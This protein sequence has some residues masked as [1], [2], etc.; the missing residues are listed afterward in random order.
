MNI[1]LAS[2][3]DASI[4]LALG[5]GLAAVLRR[6]SAAL[7]H[8]VLATAIGCAMLMPALELLMPQL[9]LVRW[10]E[11]AAATTSGLTLSSDATV[12]GAAVT[13]AESSSSS[14]AFK[15][16]ML[17]AAL[18]AAGVLV[19]LSGLVVGLWRLRRLRASCTPVLSGWRSVTD[20]LARECGVT[21]TIQVLQSTDPALLVTYG[22]FKPGIILPAGA[23]DWTEDRQ[24]VVLR[25]ELAHIRRHDAAIHV[26]GELLR[27]MQP[28]NPLVW[29]VCRRLRQESEYACDDAVL[30]AGVEP[31]VYASHLLDVAKR[32]SG[33]QTLWAAAPAIAHPSTLERRIVAML[34]HQMNRQPLTRG[35]WRLAAVFAL[36]VS[37]PLAAVGV[38]P[39]P[40]VG[41]P[42]PQSTVVTD[43][44]VATLPT[45][46][47][48]GDAPGKVVPPSRVESPAK[49]VRRAQ[50]SLSGQVQDQT[51]GRIPGAT[52]TLVNQQTQESRVAVTNAPGAFQFVN[53]PPAPYVLVTELIGFRKRQVTID[54]SAGTPA[55]LIVTLEVG[56][57]S[58]AITVQCQTPSPSILQRLFPTLLAQE[59]SVPIR[60]GGH[61]K[62]PRKAKDARPVC[63]AAGV[64][65]DV[66]VL[67]E[68][69]IGVDG[70]VTNLKSLSS[71]APADLV[72]SA[73]DA[74]LKWEFTPTLLNGVPVEVI[75]TV[76]VRYTRG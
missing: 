20:E 21:S 17:V 47:N 30:C 9:P 75:M 23:D 45:A 26:A 71:D 22:M 43:S 65:A 54:L 41:V 66:V 42:P 12:V 28:F 72:E 31:T 29:V 73:K 32:L 58:E 34:H 25:H 1:L 16:P 39:Q 13:T 61:I 68:G 37:L 64:T 69:H 76:T 55:N 2:I 7:R 49:A 18:W 51:G 3:I 70:F 36:G 46:T 74:V 60:I 67:L 11:S 56:A 24:R 4:V 15:W 10:F 48:P 27:V 63:P 57:L 8:A 53:L 33:H 44:P 35:A 19:T 62:P 38:A 52:V 59:Q 50:T 14:F 6:R 5:L 40:T